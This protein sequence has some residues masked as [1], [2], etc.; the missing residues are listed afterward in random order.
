ME[1]ELDYLRGAVLDSPKRPLTAVIGGAKVSSKLDVSRV[2]GCFVLFS[3]LSLSV[4]RSAV[5][6]FWCLCG[7][8]RSHTTFACWLLLPSRLSLSLSLPSFSLSFSLS[9]SL[10]LSLSQVL[11]TLAEKCD[12]LVI[13]GAMANTFL[14]ADGANLGAS[15]VEADFFDAA[16]AVIAKAE[17]CKSRSLSFVSIIVQLLFYSRFTFL[18]TLLAFSH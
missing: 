8:L 9:L 10:S 18:L 5:V 16:K 15:K 2:C 6:C 7:V 17:S 3:F 1:K 12:R 4:F 13:G 11:N 14:A